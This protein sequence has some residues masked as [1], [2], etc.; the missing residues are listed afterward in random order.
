MKNDLLFYSGYQQFYEMAEK[1]KAFS[2]FCREAY[3]ADLSQDGFS[4]ISQ[5][6][7]ISRHIPQGNDIC[8]LDVGCGSGKMLRYMQRKFNCFICGFDYSENAI[9]TAVSQGG[10]NCD[11]RVGTIGETDYPPMSF[12]AVISMD[13]VYFADDIVKFTSQVNSWLKEKG[14]FI[15]GYQEGDVAGKTDSCDTTL[16]ARALKENN[17]PYSVSDITEETYHLM[18]KKRE[19]VMKYKTAFENEN[20][21]Q[22]YDVILHQ[23]DSGETSFEDYRKNNARYIY[24]ARKSEKEQ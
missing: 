21:G 8:I 18:R 4:D 15:I 23:T 19:T 17:M 20:I 2:D 13:S 6:E 22:W 1:S 12:D 5:I 7:L 14:V 9:K 10:E 16:I 11:F 3:G 24:T